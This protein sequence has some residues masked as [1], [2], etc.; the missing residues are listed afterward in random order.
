MT[1]LP[2][3]AD[4]L[5]ILGTSTCWSPKILYRD[6]CTANMCSPWISRRIFFVWRIGWDFIPNKRLYIFLIF[7]YYWY[8]YERGV[9]VEM[10]HLCGVKNESITIV[11]VDRASERCIA[12]CSTFTLLPFW[13][14]ACLTEVFFSFCRLS[15]SSP[16]SRSALA[17]NS[18]LS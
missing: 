3:C 4:C 18:T 12:L 7:L 15:A 14:Q 10:S 6:S 13:N 5:E 9:L 2:P 1:I 16:S 17:S 11:L 8:N